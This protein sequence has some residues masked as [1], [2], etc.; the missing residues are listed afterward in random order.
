MSVVFVLSV[1]SV[2]SV[3]FV[4]SVV[5]V[6]FWLASLA[7]LCPHS[8]QRNVTPRRRMGL[9]GYCAGSTSGG[10]AAEKVLI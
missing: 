8:L 10:C 3:L 9:L 5:S 1:V 7:P 2:L 6:V 4:V